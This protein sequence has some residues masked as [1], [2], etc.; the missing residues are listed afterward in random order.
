MTRLATVFLAIV[1]LLVVAPAR[2]AAASTSFD[3]TSAEAE[4]VAHINDLRSAKGLQ[5]LVV[6]AELTAIARRWA[7]SMAKADQISHNPNYSKSVRSDWEKL[8]ENVGVGMT[9]EKLHAAFVASPGHYRNL[10]DPAYTYI[11]VGVVVGRDG[12]LFTAHQFMQLRPT[13][14]LAAGSRPPGRDSAVKT[15][16]STE[17]SAR[18][19]LVLEQLRELDAA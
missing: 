4:F 17:P 18:M 14:V 12:A 7:A 10:V 5:P 2:P 9:V 8:G 13:A 3:T 15:E 6:S 11:G 19:V 16:P 1:A